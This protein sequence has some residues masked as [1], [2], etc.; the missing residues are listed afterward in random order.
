M[1]SAIV[2]TW[3]FLG[4]CAPAA[5]QVS[6]GIN[7]SVYPDLVPVPGYPVYYAPRLDANF[8]FYDGLYWDYTEDSWY[9]SSWYNGPWD[10]VTPE[11]VPL[12][13]LRVPVRYYRR[14]PPYFRGWGPEAPPRWGEHWGHG[15]EQRRVGW[16]HWDRA[17]VPAAAPLPTYQRKFS[18]GRYP[19]FDK[20]LTLRN[21]NYRYQPHEAVVR[22]QYH[23]SPGQVALAEPYHSKERPGQAAPPRKSQPSRSR[24]QTDMSASAPAHE[25]KRGPEH[26]RDR[27]RDHDHDQ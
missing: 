1:R 8:F 17:S 21:Q 18:G 2:V 10:R 13:V 26:D 24:Q 20:Q 27:D 22:Q 6:V 7:L 12:F 25:P 16:D 3:M 5:A 4:A 23:Q 14:P 11:L 15:W 19:G 9:T